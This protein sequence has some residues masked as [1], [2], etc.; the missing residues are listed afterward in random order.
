MLD[1]IFPNLKKII[2][3]IKIFFYSKD[4]H[5][6]HINICLLWRIFLIVCML[7]LLFLYIKNEFIKL[8]QFNLSD[9]NKNS[10]PKNEFNDKLNVK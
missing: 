9:E 10:T 5:E 8:G 6:L 1:R 3:N 2:S 7:V 4:C